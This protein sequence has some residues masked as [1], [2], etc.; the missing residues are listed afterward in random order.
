M[1]R[2]EHDPA[3]KFLVKNFIEET[4]IPLSPSD[5]FPVLRVS[6]PVMSDPAVRRKSVA[7]CIE[8]APELLI[9]K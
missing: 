2:T 1:E 8:Y 6:Q 7:W 3:I 4:A 5:P 9:I